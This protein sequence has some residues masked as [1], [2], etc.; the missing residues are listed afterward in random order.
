MI[1]DSGSQ[2][3]AA[4]ISVSGQGGAAGPVVAKVTFT[5]AQLA[6][7]R[8]LLLQPGAF[9]SFLGYTNPAQVISPTAPA[10]KVK[11]KFHK[12]R[13]MTRKQARRLS[14]VRR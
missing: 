4:A 6:G 12:V 9:S 7:A 2:V 14:R 3:A 11:G 8:S 13:A 1:D 5:P 10:S